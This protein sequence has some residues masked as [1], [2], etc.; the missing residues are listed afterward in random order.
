VLAPV[1]RLC[2]WCELNGWTPT[3]EAD[4]LEAERKRREADEVRAASFK[5]PVEPR[6]PVVDEDGQVSLFVI[7]GCIGRD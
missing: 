7:V 4:V 1:A 5:P 3:Y 6:G 2:E